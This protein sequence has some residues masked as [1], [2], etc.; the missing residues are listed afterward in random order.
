M[1][2]YCRECLAGLPHCHGTLIRHPGQH[3]Q[4]TEPD[5]THPDMFLHSLSIDCAAI[6]CECCAYDDGAIAV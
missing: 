5:C 4:C 1:G 3:L 2:A 6:G